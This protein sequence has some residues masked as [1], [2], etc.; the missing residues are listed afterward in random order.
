MQ[1]NIGRELGTLQRIY[2]P[3]MQYGGTDDD[4]DFCLKNFYDLC[5]KVGI[6]PH[7]LGDFFS[8]M[9][10]G[11][12]REYYYDR[13]TGHIFQFPQMVSQIKQNFETNKRCQQLLLIW[14]TISLS[15]FI[16]KYP[17]K[18]VLKSFTLT[19]ITPARL[20]L[21][22]ITSTIKTKL[23]MIHIKAE[24]NHVSFSIRATDNFR[25]RMKERG[26]SFNNTK[27]R[28][29][30]VEFEGICDDEDD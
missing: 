7:I 28:Q 10:K 25:K 17:E 11:R 21:N 19:V 16:K 4:F 5:R 14:N 2:Q 8:V 22:T 1:G 26:A 13:I 27:I 23:D 6:L 3:D 15:S 12:A 18:S 24:P 9:L 20:D 30:I 29:F